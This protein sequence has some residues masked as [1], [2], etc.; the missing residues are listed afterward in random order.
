MRKTKIV[1]TIGPASGSASVIEAMIQNGMNVVR[2]NFSHGSHLDHAE[3]IRTVRD[4]STRLDVPIAIIQDL[5]GPKIRVGDIPDPGIRLTPGQ[6]FVLTNQEVVGTE[7]RVSVSYINLPREVQIGDRLLLADGL[8]ELVVKKTSPTDIYCEVIT[9]GILTSHKGI[10]LPTATISAPALT[11]K[12]KED[13]LFGLEHDV[14]YVALSFVRSAEDLEVVKDIIRDHGKDTPVIAKIEKH[15]AVEHMDEIV[16]AAGGIM[17]ARGD[18]GVEIPLEDVPLIQKTLI[19]Q[20]NALGKPVITA[21]QM[22]R[23]MVDSPR[24]TRAEATD[25]ANAVLDGTDAVMLSEETAVGNYPVEAVNFMH[26]IADNAEKGFPHDR[27]LQAEPGKNISESVAQAS[28]MLAN[29]LHASAIVAPTQSGQTARYISRFRPR[30]PIIALSPNPKTVR[31]L[32][33]L[34]GCLPRLVPNPQDTDD[35]FEIAARGALETGKVASGDLVV[36]TAGHPIWVAGSTNMLQV[37]K[38]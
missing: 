19:R 2:L 11:D 36:I 21:T 5:G 32:T 9:G 17:V 38:L 15:E 22:L 7:H 31:R 28:C 26:R 4:I 30:Q 20:A 25:V 29:N 24:P 16:Q 18:L 14:D 23:S 8:L 1:C 10:N 6:T 34:W 37:K 13:L 3:K 12:D 27:F 33:L 35:L